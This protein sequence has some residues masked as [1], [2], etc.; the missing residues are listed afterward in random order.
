MPDGVDEADQL[1]LIS[2]EGAVSRRDEAAEIGDG[3]F[4]L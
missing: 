3:V 1:P 2:G 4:V